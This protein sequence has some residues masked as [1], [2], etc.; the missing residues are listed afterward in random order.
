MA[1]KA[2]T[3]SAD[4]GKTLQTIINLWPYMWPS[5]RPDLKL[6]VV[7]ATVFLLLSKVVLLA[8]P[9]FFKWST[10]ALNGKIDVAGHP[11]DFHARRAD[12]CRRL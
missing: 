10:D 7:W 12:A 5:E 1:D 11:A 3:V 8:V 4:S 9:Y 2:K 6:R